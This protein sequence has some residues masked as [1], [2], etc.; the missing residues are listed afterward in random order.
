MFQLMIN[1]LKDTYSSFIRKLSEKANSF[2]DSQLLKFFIKIIRLLLL[3]ASILSAKVNQFFENSQLLKNWIKINQSSTLL[4][5]TMAIIAFNLSYNKYQEDRIKM[6]EDRIT[7]AWDTLTKMAGQNSNGGQ[8]NAIEILV[9]NSIPLDHIDLS[10][11]YLRGANLQGASLKGADLSNADL[12]EANLQGADL[13]G[14]NLNY[15]KLYHANLGGASFDKAS[16]TGTKLAFG[17]VDI[18]VI[19]SKSLNNADLTGVLF[20]LEDVYGNLQWDLYGDT[21]AESPE[22]DNAQYKIN[23]ACALTHFNIKQ[24]KALP[25]KLPTRLCGGNTN[26]NLIQNKFYETD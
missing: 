26:Y 4:I 15:A 9:S 8:I 16:L 7:K 23:N 20:V 25:I 17:T 13:T 19:L 2:M 12:I 10:N 14:A 3:F 18:G 6:D 5:L 21:I 24:N 1:K 22:A 11:T